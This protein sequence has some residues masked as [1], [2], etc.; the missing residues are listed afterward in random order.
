LPNVTYGTGPITLG[1]TAS[2]GLAVSYAVTGPATLNGNKLTLTGVGT[3]NVTASQTGNTDYAAATPVSQAFKVSA[4]SQTI[5]FNA[6]PA[7]TVG[8]SVALSAS[9]SSGLAVSFSSLT[10]TVCTV[11]GT[12]A[13]LV[14]T[15]TCSIQASQA[16]NA[17]YLA[18]TS[19]TQSFTVS[20]GAGFTITALPGSET[21]FR[22]I[23]VAFLLEIQPVDGFKGNV[24]LTC[25]G[26]PAGA[27]CAD[28]PQTV[29]VN[30]TAWAISGMLF[31]ENTTP[32]T[33]TITFTGTSGSVTASGTATFTVK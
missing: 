32:G 27:E 4:A 28:L 25:S 23:L 11:S 13:K 33:Y 19:V 17:D 2:S 21:A 15:G 3:V 14:T 16:G 22:G 30:G 1:A 10:A 6:I 29:P 26:G 12:T 7:Q 5:T 31:P 18:A 24:K 8:G 20:S 9:A